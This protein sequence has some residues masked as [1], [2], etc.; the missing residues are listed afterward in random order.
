MSSKPRSTPKRENG[1]IDTEAVEA[2]FMASPY[3]DWT[4]FAEEQGWDPFRS[5]QDFPIRKWIENKRHHLTV[6]QVDLL[7]G[8]FHERKYK[9]AHELVK[10]LDTHPEFIEMGVHIA[11]AKLSQLADMFRDYQENFIGK[12]EK[13]YYKGKNGR[14]MRRMH[15]FEKVSAGQIGALLAGMKSIS[16]AKFKSL[17]LDN[18]AI[19]KVNLSSDQAQTDEGGEAK[20]VGP[21]FTIEGKEVIDIHEL[22]T[23][24]DKYHDKPVLPASDEADVTEE[25]KLQNMVDEASKFVDPKLNG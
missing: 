5:R 9:W 22:Q 8:L 10:T 25:K 7:S 1:T 4:R 12:P 15:P 19:T 3:L 6:N 16:D 24:F 11:K 21:M 14:G 18:F 13:M 23:W 20:Q 2:M 17:L